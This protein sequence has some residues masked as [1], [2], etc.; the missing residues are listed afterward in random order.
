MKLIKLYEK[1]RC[2]GTR[3]WTVI[4][5]G[6]T[7]GNWKEIVDEMGITKGIQNGVLRM[8]LEIASLLSIFVVVHLSKPRLHDTTCFQTGCHTG[9]TTG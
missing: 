8:P 7:E 6:R 1:G 4:F 3:G 2:C 5:V 9:L